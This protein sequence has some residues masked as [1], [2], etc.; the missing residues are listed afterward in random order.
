MNGPS[1]TVFKSIDTVLFDEVIFL[2]RSKERDRWNLFPEVSQAKLLNVQ[3]ME[4]ASLPLRV[5]PKQPRKSSRPSKMQQ[6]DD[7]W[8]S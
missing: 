6:E 7:S 4:N 2:F 8:P 3:N 1:L 5:R